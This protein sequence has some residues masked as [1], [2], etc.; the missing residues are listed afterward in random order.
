MEQNNNYLVVLYTA[1][2]GYKRIAE[3]QTEEK[4]VMVKVVV[5][6]INQENQ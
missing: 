3:S 1:P 5:N 4:E 6:L 2:D